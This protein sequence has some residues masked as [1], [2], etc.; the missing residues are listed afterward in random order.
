MSLIYRL[1]DEGFSRFTDSGDLRV[2]EESGT[3]DI[4]EQFTGAIGP[5]D[6][7]TI[8]DVDNAVGDFAMSGPVLR[9]GNNLVTATLISLFSDRLAA[10]DDEIPDRTLDRRGWWGDQDQAVPI[11]SRLWLLDRAKMTTD[12][13]AQAKGYAVEALA[14]MIADG[15]AQRTDVTALVPASGMLAMRIVISR[16]SGPD[17]ALNFAWVWKEGN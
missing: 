15:V 4:I 7:S 6:I 13:P 1:T 3:A 17:V 11:G 10:A 5:G 14:W 2:L 8:W 16:R 9:S 12:L